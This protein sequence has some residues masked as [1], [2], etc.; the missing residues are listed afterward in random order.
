MG[1][2]PYEPSTEQITFTE[3]LGSAHLGAG[4]PVWRRQP[5]EE[6]GTVE[7]LLVAEAAQRLVALVIRRSGRGHHLVLL[8]LA[9]ITDVAAGVVHVALSDDQLDALAPYQPP[10]P[11]QH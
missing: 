11:D 3:P 4:T 8:P 6:V 9:A 7:R 5:H 2:A 1:A 10:P